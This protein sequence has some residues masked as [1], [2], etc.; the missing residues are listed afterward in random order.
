MVEIDPSNITTVEAI[1]ERYLAFGIFDF[2]ESARK[3]S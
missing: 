2:D 1:I 3:A